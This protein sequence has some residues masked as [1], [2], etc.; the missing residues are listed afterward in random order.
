MVKII[1]WIQAI[2]RI[3]RIPEAWI[4]INLETLSATCTNFQKILTL[5]R[6]IE[7]KEF[8]QQWVWAQNISGS[9]SN[10]YNYYT[11]EAPYFMHHWFCPIYPIHLI[12]KNL[13][14]LKTKLP[15]IEIVVPSIETIGIN[16]NK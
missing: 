12:D 5:I 1:Y 11:I 16:W 15:E 8:W 14:I 13:F 4:A 2:Q 7:E 6:W 9:F 3:L 10:P